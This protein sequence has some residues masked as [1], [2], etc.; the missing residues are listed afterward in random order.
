M[1]NLTAL[2]THVIAPEIFEMCVPRDLVP[3]VSAEV[4]D[5]LDSFESFPA[6]PDSCLE[7]GDPDTCTSSASLVGPLEPDAS[8][9]LLT[10]A[11]RVKSL[12]HVL[13]QHHLLAMFNL[14]HPLHL[15]QQLRAEFL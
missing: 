12:P 5:C 9:A 11:L 4:A 8:P 6:S 10:D 7:F 1:G 15:Y 13:L 2:W 3:F 14:M